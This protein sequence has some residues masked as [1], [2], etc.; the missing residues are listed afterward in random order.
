MAV[1]S[2]KIIW[3]GDNQILYNRMMRMIRKIPINHKYPI[4]NIT[5]KWLMIFGR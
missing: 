4:D 2:S 1:I 5:I 3:L